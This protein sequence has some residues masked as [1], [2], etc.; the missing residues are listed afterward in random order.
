MW[1]WKLPESDQADSGLLSNISKF[2]GHLR[3]TALCRFTR[4]CA[5]EYGPFS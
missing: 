4:Y 3:Y 5:L 1:Y 2:H